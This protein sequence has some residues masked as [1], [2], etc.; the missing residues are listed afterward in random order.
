MQPE[1]RCAHR[2]RPEEL[3]YIQFEPEG[4]GI[5]LNASEQGLAFHAAAAMR[6]PGPIR[7]CISPNPTQRIEVIAEIAWID[8]S[9][10]SGGVRFTEL[11][12]DSQKQ[13]R[14]WLEQ[15]T[16]SENPDRKFEV[17]SRALEETAPC[18]HPQHDNSGLSV[19]TAVPHNALTPHTGAATI[20]R[21]CGIPQA[22][23][24]WEAL[25]QK[26]QTSISEARL[27]GRVAKGFLIIAFVSMP[28]LLLHNFRREIGNSL[29]TIGEKL[30]G[31]SDTPQASS[32][33]ISVPISSPRSEG[34]S[35]IPKPN[36]E[37]PATDIPSQP[38]PPAAAATNQGTTNAV[39]PS[40]ADRQHLRQH[41]ADAHPSAGRRALARQ[42]WS[43]IGAG[44]TSAEVRL[45]QLYLKGDGVPKNCEQARVLLRAASRNGNIEALQQLQKLNR[46]GCR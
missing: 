40:V 42:L 4:G 38:D 46:S 26:D 10:K 39:D 15:T 41:S 8:E 9:K 3:S 16:E 44:D 21:S 43:A 14:R 29:I 1:R 5:V 13:I 34:T 30:K 12:A 35:S 7:I 18:S 17:L 24:M 23:P 19:A 31:N 33:S 22:A 2:T 25:F 20:S 37:P 36:P 27:L 32:S 45:A 6:Q 28:I 11:T